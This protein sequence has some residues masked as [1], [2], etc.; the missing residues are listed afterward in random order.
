MTTAAPASNPASAEQF[1][2]MVT[3]AQWRNMLADQQVERDANLA[4]SLRK[5]IDEADVAQ[6][7]APHGLSADG[8]PRHMIA[9]P[10]VR[11]MV[12]S[13]TTSH[14]PGLIGKDGRIV[15]TP[16]GAPAGV[17]LNMAAGLL[18]GSRIAHAG[19]RVIVAPPAVELHPVGHTGV[20]V[21][22][23]I[24]VALRNIEAARF[25][26]VAGGGL[27]GVTFATLDKDGASW[28]DGDAPVSSLP[29]FGAE[30]DWRASV[31]KG[32]RFEIPRSERRR[33]DP[34]QLCAEILASLSLGLARAADDVLLSAL[35]AA[36]LAPFTLADAA[37]AGL[38][39]DELRALIGTAGS[40]AVIGQDGAL[41]AAGIAA[42]LTA[43]TAG[44]FVGAWNRAGVAVND[45]I[46]IYA[47]RL[48]KAGG[49]AV[50]AWASMLPLVPD[51][52]KFFTVA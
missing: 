33:V 19:A 24:P 7:Y 29:V 8:E 43:E 10:T 5:L 45:E 37:A 25:G 52:N 41:R 1:R 30:I 42:E 44:T 3:E 4:L 26:T 14:L 6:K 2:N 36:S 23:R 49:M 28:D 17:T 50:T 39:F 32:V 48:G 15:R 22:E 51:A 16:K 34:D 20:M 12:A 46:T 9:Q 31:S 40:G 27:D 38:H 11:S 18:A 13:L 35:D 47:E 21:V